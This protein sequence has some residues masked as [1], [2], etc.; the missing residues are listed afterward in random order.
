[1]E[2]LSEQ[3]E[4][5]IRSHENN[6]SEDYDNFNKLIELEK[7]KKLEEDKDKNKNKNKNNVKK[8]NIK[9]IVLLFFLSIILNNNYFEQLI[10]KISNLTNEYIIIAIKSIIFTIIFISTKFIIV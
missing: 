1:M 8:Y 6:N 4:E 3:I 10:K 5:S 7:N 2:Q 9:E